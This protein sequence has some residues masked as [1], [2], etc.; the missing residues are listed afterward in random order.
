[1][2]C[3]LGNY[4]GPLIQIRETIYRFMYRDILQNHIVLFSNEKVL[5]EL[6]FQ[7][8]NDSKHCSKLIVEFVTKY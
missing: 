1:M 2:G 6:S 3:F 8:D 7:H 5:I 4:P